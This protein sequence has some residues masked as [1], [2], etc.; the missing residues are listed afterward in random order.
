MGGYQLPLLNLINPTF[1]INNQK[2]V[3][4]EFQ[5]LL[6]RRFYLLTKGSTKRMIQRKFKQSINNEDGGILLRNDQI[7]GLK[8]DFQDK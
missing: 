1:A 2:M 5:Q 4:K 3:R 6:F 7:N 8:H